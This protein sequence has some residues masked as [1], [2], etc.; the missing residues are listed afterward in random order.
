VVS[1]SVLEL[2]TLER[3]CKT[4]DQRLCVSKRVKCLEDKRRKSRRKN[5]GFE[6]RKR[7]KLGSKTPVWCRHKG[8]QTDGSWVERERERAGSVVR[9][10]ET[11]KFTIQIRSCKRVH[12]F[13]FVVMCHLVERE[14]GAEPAAFIVQTSEVD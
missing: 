11:S 6:Q 9:R 1:R 8:V 4:S 13:R 14:K 7:F 2:L 12:G 10:G 3:E 5:K